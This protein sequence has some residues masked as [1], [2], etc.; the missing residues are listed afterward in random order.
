MDHAV[1]KGKFRVSEAI[2]E[3]TVILPLGDLINSI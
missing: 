2:T 1:D 3:R